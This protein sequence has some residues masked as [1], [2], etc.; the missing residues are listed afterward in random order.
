MQPE[1]GNDPFFNLLLEEAESLM[2]RANN[3]GPENADPSYVARIFARLADAIYRRL[4]PNEVPDF[5]LGAVAQTAESHFA[6]RYRQWYVG[7]TA[8]LM[9]NCLQSAINEEG[10]KIEFPVF[11]YDAMSYAITVKPLPEI[12]IARTEY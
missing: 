11:D 4:V 7:Q 12:T 6:R 9:M 1:Q 3:A 2:A 5:D 10:R 8:R